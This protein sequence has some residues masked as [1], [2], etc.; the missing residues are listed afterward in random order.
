[1]RLTFLLAILSAS[2]AAAAT[3][4]L[5][6]G[7]VSTIPDGSSSGIAR[8]LT[9]SG[10]GEFVATAEVDLNLSAAPASS[11]FLG[12]LYIYLTNG[13]FLSVLTNRAGRSATAP[14]GYGDNQPVTVTFS[15][16]GANDF[17]TY[18]IP[19]TGSATTALS[20]PLTGTWQPDGRTTDP[21]VVLNTDPRPAGLNVFTGVP[22]DGTWSLFAAD[23]STG[24]VHQINSWTLRLQTVPE[25]G[26]AGLAGAAAVFL[27]AR[28]RRQRR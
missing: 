4:T 15:A 3:I 26:T 1:M 6:D 9:V 19:V 23:L 27:L 11:A 7:V 22:A 5:T 20:G 21:A 13:T 14:A 28:R 10:S 2:S 8:N 16:A 24:A 25:P 18:R 12:D 17:H